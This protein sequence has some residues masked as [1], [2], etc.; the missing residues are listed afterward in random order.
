[1]T[2]Q[3]RQGVLPEWEILELRRMMAL[4]SLETVKD[5]LFGLAAAGVITEEQ[6]VA[7]WI[8]VCERST[9]RERSGS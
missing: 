9:E 6:R 1:M 4:E 7:I 2:E 8:R 5:V 3:P